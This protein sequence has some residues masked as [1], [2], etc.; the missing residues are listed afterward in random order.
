ML[1]QS[2]AKHT[3]KILATPPKC[4]PHTPINA[5]MKQLADKEGCSRPSSHEKLLF[6]ERISEASKFIV[7]SSCPL[8]IISDNICH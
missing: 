2:C 6:R 3:H 8:S 4:R 1:N 5:F 7:G